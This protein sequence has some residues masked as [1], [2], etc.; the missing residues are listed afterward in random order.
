MLIY[1]NPDYELFAAD[2]RIPVG[3]HHHLTF[4]PRSGEAMAGQIPSHVLAGFDAGIG[5]T[6][7]L[8]G[9]QAVLP[10]PSHF[11][12]VDRIQHPVRPG[13]GYQYDFK[14]EVWGRSRQRPPRSRALPGVVVCLPTMD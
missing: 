6:P 10:T 8:P 4:Q 9:N 2:F 7:A 1:H 12:T 14:L 3:S 11:I 13:P 5:S